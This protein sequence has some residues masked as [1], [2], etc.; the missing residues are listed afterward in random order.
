LSYSTPQAI[1]ITPS[2]GSS[3]PGEAVSF[4][5]AYQDADGYTDIRYS[6]L[7]I[8]TSITP[9]EG[10]YAYY[11]TS[12]NKLYLRNDAGTAW[13]EGFAPG[14][15]NTIENSYAI[16]DCSQTTVQGQDNN[17]TITW[18]VT[19]KDTFAGNKNCYLF[20]RDYQDNMSGWKK[21]GTWGIEG[22]PPPTMYNLITSVV[23]EEG[24]APFP[25]RVSS[26]G[27]FNGDGYSD[28]VVG[29][30]E[31]DGS[32]NIGKCYVYFG[33]DP[34]N[35]EP[36]LVISGEAPDD[37]FAYSLMGLGDINNDGYD[38]I[39]VGAPN[40]DVNGPVSG[41]AYIYF[42]GA[43][44]DF[45]DIADV[46]IDGQTAGG[47]F[48]HAVAF[49]GDINNDGYDDI[50]IGA[51]YE[52][53]VAAYAGKVYIYLG[54]PTV[55]DTAD[56]TING[57]EAEDLFGISI[58]S[59]GD[60]NNDG[61]DDIIIGASGYQN[62]QT[63]KSGKAY[64]YFGGTPPDT[65]ADVTINGEAVGDRFG[66]SLAL[67]KDINGD[68]NC[69][70]IIGAE[71]ND[72]LGSDTGRVYVYFGGQAIDDIED[73][74][75]TGE[76]PEDMF[77]SSV[78]L[79][80]DINGDGFADIMVGAPNNDAQGY[81]HG[82]AYIYLG[83][84]AVDS[85]ADITIAPDED[86]AGFGHSIASAGDIDKDGIDEIIVSAY[87]YSPNIAGSIYI[88]DIIPGLSPYRTPEGLIDETQALSCKYFYEQILTTPEAYGLIKDTC[89]TNYS[90]IAATGFGLT[91]LCIMADRY[92][93]SS[94]WGITPS[95]A[96]SRAAAT[97]D[98]L[99]N[100]QN[101]QNGQEY[102]YGK[103]GF[104]YHFVNPNGQREILL[105]SEVSTIDTAILLAGVLT[106]G[107]YF[108]GEVKVKANEIFDNVNWS[109]F[110][111]PG[112]KQFYH[113]WH[114]Y[115]GMLQQT[116]DRAGDETLLISML[117]IASDPT[118]QD[119]LESFFS[120]PRSRNSYASADET[121][122]VYNSYSGSLFTYIFAHCWY[123][124]KVVGNDIPQN[125]PGAVFK[126]PINWWENSKTAA[127]ANRQ[128]CIDNSSYYPSYGENSWGLS[129]CYR[130][131]G[132]YFGMNSAPPREYIPPEGGE[133]VHDGTVPPYGAISALPFMKDLETEEGLPSNLAFKALNHY[134]NTYY[135]ELWGVYG[136]RD[137]F[138]DL[139]EFSTLY[140]GI[141][142]GPIALMIENY[143]SGLI[144]NIFMN[145][146]RV[147]EVTQA[148]FTD[149][150]SPIVDY[151][152]VT[153][154]ESPTAGYSGSATVSVIMYE[155]DE[156]GSVTKWLITETSSRPSVDDFQVSGLDS[157][158][159]TY[160][161]MGGD[162]LKRLYAWVMDKSGNISNISGSSQAEIYLDTTQPL[163]Y[164]VIDDGAYT[165][166]STELSC[167]WSG[168]DNESGVI[169]YQYCIMEGSPGGQVIR[170]WTSVGTQNT[171]EAEG[172]NLVKGNSYYFGIKARNGAGSWCGPSYSDGIIVDPSVPDLT[173]IDPVSGSFVYVNT[174]VLISSIV[175]NL[176]GDPVEYQ[177]WVNGIIKQYWDALDTYSW[178]AQGSDMGLAE[179]K[180]EVRDDD[181][182]D[183]GESRIYVV[184]PLIGPPSTN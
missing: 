60:V 5:A 58:D 47:A 34:I 170:S 79:A 115:N 10:F 152:E 107:E 166:V 57:E 15:A 39:V 151:F 163:I 56:I 164:S 169:E 158:P 132:S 121:F 35:S 157:R 24:M 137:S 126:V 178:H 91:A 41:K 122:Y 89:F 143:R 160:E 43:A 177:F 133:P 141:D 100:I 83:G 171:V 74:T 30:Q 49:S 111:N 161:I 146:S 20:V 162:G 59:D 182:V 65:T 37:Y 104:F 179:I 98:T 173:D 93:T 64:I 153:D 127:R 22:V 78:A 88:Y 180:V 68:G 1:S 25:C 42:G 76:A 148:L 130:P 38:D 61:I 129:A 176:D 77:G 142:A 147:N 54:G 52:S 134:Y 167:R 4:T 184:H 138:N 7:S 106:A 102:L 21:L 46:T 19:F 144:W 13:L 145:D 135:S 45:D 101:N 125:V 99:L 73:L 95:Q 62:G 29:I 12:Q 84:V 140:L 113:G 51:P 128:F 86:C 63:E 50:I 81:N 119:F 114:P 120:F 149:M 136:P 33:G 17:L 48:G 2:H 6:Y 44:S 103:E 131:D 154:P 70:V 172:L 123:D 72:E 23:Y 11:N 75:L 97:L 174:S 14:S 92:G 159:V 116:W 139:E 9:T 16:L 71:G 94:Y 109:Y 26:T 105:N 165:A 156:A 181:G 69:D 108:G 183:F 87:I 110:L 55:D 118:N 3:T 27:D 168:K 85:I 32:V 96:Y 67:A 18:S 31:K 28:I 150:T 8:N 53:S 82:K 80:R 117:A 112:N 90:S 66:A 40:S 155:H 124:F 36:D 175:D